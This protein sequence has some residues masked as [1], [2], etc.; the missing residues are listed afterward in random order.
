MK[1]LRCHDPQWYIKCAKKRDDSLQLCHDTNCE[2]K[3]EPHICKQIFSTLRC[4]WSN[5]NYI[6]KR[7]F[8]LM[9]GC[10]PLWCPP[11][12][13]EGEGICQI[14]TDLSPL[15]FRL[16]LTPGITELK[17]HPQSP[18]GAG[19]LLRTTSISSARGERCLTPLETSKWG[20]QEHYAPPVGYK[21]WNPQL[22]F[23][24]HLPYQYRKYMS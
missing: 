9:T 12:W 13:R 21:H 2:H 8:F 6:Y 16:S 19:L 17:R 24:I 5:C 11:R 7:H 14:F 20:A 23:I 15:V 4:K 1:S 18:T 22:D 10:N 3:N